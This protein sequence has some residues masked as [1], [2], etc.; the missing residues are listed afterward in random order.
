[1]SYL[2]LAFSWCCMCFDVYAEW[3]LR[4][5]KKGGLRDFVFGK[6]EAGADQVCVEAGEENIEVSR[7]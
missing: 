6:N 3:V 4:I 2:L 1:M 5:G 7:I